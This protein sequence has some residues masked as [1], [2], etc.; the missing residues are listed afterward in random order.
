MRLAGK[1]VLV[2][3]AAHGI[4]RAAAEASVAEGAQVFASDIDMEALSDLAGP[5][6]TC[7]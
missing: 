7:S 5:S 4:G 1:R 2:T 3:A 6:R